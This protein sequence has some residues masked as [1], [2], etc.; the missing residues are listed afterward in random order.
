MTDSA[1]QMIDFDLSDAAADSRLKLS[2][3]S[4]IM[5]TYF[6]GKQALSTLRLLSESRL[7]E[8]NCIV[9]DNGSS[10]AEIEEIEGS[11]PKAMLLKLGENRGF[12]Y[13]V[14]IGLHAAISR[15]SRVV[16]LVNPDVKFGPDV[17]SKVVSVLHAHPDLWLVGPNQHLHSSLIARSGGHAAIHPEEGDVDVKRVERISG[18]F[19]ALRADV[20]TRIGF[21]DQDYFLY[22]EDDDLCCR[23]RDL[24]GGIGEVK[25]AAVFHD[26]SSGSMGSIPFR[27]YHATRG[28]FIFM[29]KHRPP[30]GM[31]FLRGL[32]E[33]VFTFR[34]FGAAVARGANPIVCAGSAARGLVDGSTVSL[35]S[36]H[37]GPRVRRS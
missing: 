29:R 36:F 35:S 3:V 8:C 5:V 21:L 25:S 2:R 13:A 26:I 15:G 31:M 30:I 20:V 12:S 37:E 7:P 22:R 23:V 27:L 18:F 4:A 9:V 32:H 17:P 34:D 11:F 14:N 19:V 1:C 24:G 33:L 10:D 28:R 16:L 6:S